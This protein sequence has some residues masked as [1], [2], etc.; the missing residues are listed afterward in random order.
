MREDVT[1]VESVC[2]WRM[3]IAALEEPAHVAQ[4]LAHGSDPLHLGERTVVCFETEFSRVE[5]LKSKDLD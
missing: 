5:R 1:S 3:K 4:I 2:Q